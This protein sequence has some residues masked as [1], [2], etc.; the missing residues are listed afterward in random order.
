MWRLAIDNLRAHPGRVLRTC[1]A[2]VLGVA[3]LAGTLVLGDTMRAGFAAAFS[4]AY[5]GVDVV[6]RGTD[7]MGSDTA[8]QVRLVPPGVLEE[9]RSVEGVARTVG[10]ITGPTQVTGADGRPVGGNGPPTEGENWIEGPESPWSLAEGRAPRRSGEVVLDR[11]TARAGGLSVGTRTTV[12]TPEPVTVTVV[13]IAAFGQ[14][15]SIGGSGYT[16]FTEGDARRFVLGGAPGWTSLLVRAE[17]G[18]DPAAL[19]DRIAA[20]LPD[21]V[22]ALTGAEA[23]ALA[24][25]QVG[26]EFLDAFSWLLLGFTAVALLVAGFSI[27]NTFSVVLA[28]R[29]RA[30]ALTRAL[31]ATR[32]QV[33][34]SALVESAAIGVLASV[35]GSALGLGL[36]AGLRALV[37]GFGVD[38][39]GGI[40]LEPSSLVAAALIGAVITVL[41]GL[42]PAVRA[43][44]IAPIEA[45]RVAEVDRSAAPRVRAVAGALL[46]GTGAAMV[47][48]AAVVRPDAAMGLAAAGSAVC[49]VGVLVLGPAV[50]RPVAAVLGWPLRSFGGATGSLARDNAM[51]NPRRSAA[52]ASALLI[53]VCVVTL[54]TVMGSSLSAMVRAA[55][56]G[57]VHADL[58]VVESSF[59]GSGF[60]SQL[61]GAV[62]E[63]DA[64]ESASGIGFGAARLDGREEEL[65]VADPAAMAAALDAGEVAGS[66]AE[67]RDDQLAVARALADRRGW[68]L[69]TPVQVTFVDGSSVPMTIGAIYTEV[70]L[71]GFA[72]VP[73]ATWA[74]HSTFDLDMVVAVELADGT[75]PGTAAAAIGEVTDRFG[76]PA[77]QTPAEYAE[78]VAGELEQLL[79]VVY[80]LLALSIVIALMGIANTLAL[81]THERVRELGLLRALGQTRRQ[82]RRMV[83]AEAVVLASLGTLGGVALGLFLA[84]GLVRAMATL[85]LGVT[86][87]AAPAGTL[88]AI[89]GVGAA[90]GAVAAWRPA[91]RAARLDVIEALSRP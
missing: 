49:L 42:A 56:V 33:L 19:R 54:F 82:V 91:R 64:V 20:T 8:R 78:Q 13:G 40:E 80:V 17:P 77:P 43:S 39:P 28:Q 34:G 52:T 37:A 58:L 38:L 4:D 60:S 26:E 74:R 10:S 14:Q 79:G 53:G 24:E 12:R 29:S 69:G 88:A 16:A 71:A 44:R 46:G 90:A 66:L 87:F 51:R 9:I 59:S 1:S 68:Q 36:A 18:V 5:A 76:A 7:A 35:T 73:R 41:A 84:W 22:E 25:Q 45:L 57:T 47:L 31:G 67:L 30:A 70:Q 6:V 89:C 3:F 62:E 15:D 27:H 85:D 55:V 32:R 63:L 75:D 81:S 61:A 72:V 50:A 83:R 21:G 11:A 65:T 23:A 86:A 48:W 2:V